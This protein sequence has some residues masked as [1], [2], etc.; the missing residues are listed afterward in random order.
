MLKIIAKNF[1]WNHHGFLYKCNWQ[2]GLQLI[3]CSGT[4]AEGNI[5]HTRLTA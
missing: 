4:A 5:K 3:A 1:T 2:E